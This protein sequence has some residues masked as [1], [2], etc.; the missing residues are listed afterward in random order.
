MLCRHFVWREQVCFHEE[1]RMGPGFLERR[2][3]IPQQMLRR[4][5]KGTGRIQRDG[6]LAAQMTLARR[7]GQCGGVFEGGAGGLEAVGFV[8]VVGDAEGGDDVG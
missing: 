6:P 3:G 1:V 4:R 7:Q 2:S 5:T 8:D